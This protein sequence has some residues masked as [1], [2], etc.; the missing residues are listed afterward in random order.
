MARIIPQKVRELYKGLGLKT[1]FYIHLR[2]MLCPFEKIAS[3]LPVKGTIFDVGCGYGLLANYL[4]LSSAERKVIGVDFSPCRI[5]IA[6]KTVGQ[7]K[8]IEFLKKDVKDLNLELCDGLVVSDFLH[9]I[10][11][12]AARSF[13]QLIH[14]RIKPGGK[15][16]IQEVDRFPKWKY[17]ATITID[18]LLNP[19]K[20]LYYCPAGEW[21]KRLES[22][23]FRVR[24][25]PIHQG[26]PL[27]DILF[28]CEKM[29][30]NSPHPN[31]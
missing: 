15:L 9:H 2:W 22:A 12:E 26:L 8:N 31:P 18:K 23:G 24:T 1:W 30:G 29:L 21:K 7:R 13:F 6:K 27:A 3:F 5:R 4:S 11:P 25:I 28:I 10:K 17:F 20:P 16:I 14:K 19:G